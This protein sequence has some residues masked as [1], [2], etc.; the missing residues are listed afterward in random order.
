MSKHF[1][2]NSWKIKEYH[3]KINEN[4]WMVVAFD[5]IQTVLQ[6][7]NLKLSFKPAEHKL[8]HGYVKNSYK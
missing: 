6:T 7:V 1:Q 5:V 4:E 8:E 3:S 2:S